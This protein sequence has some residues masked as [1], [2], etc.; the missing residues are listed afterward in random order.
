MT[1][2]QMLENQSDF[3]KHSEAWIVSSMPR[4]GLQM[5]QP[6]NVGDAW[7]KPYARQFHTEDAPTWRAIIEGRPLRGD[8][9]WPGGLE[10]S[11]YY[12]GFLRPGG[13]RYMA[14]AP[15]AAPVMEGYAGAIHVYRT[16]E[17]G[18]FSDQEL[19]RLSEIAGELNKA[20]S[21]A[22]AIR[23]PASCAV[24]QSWVHRP[25]TRQLVL[26]AKLKSCLG[27]MHDLDDRV[28]AQ[29]LSDA[30]KRLQHA[31]GNAVAARLAVPDTH[32]DLWTFRVMPYPY[33]PAFGQGPVLFYCMQPEFCDWKTIRSTD[34][35]ADESVAR[36]IPALQYMQEEFYKGPTLNQIAKTVHLSPFH[37]HRRFADLL[38]ITPKHFLL[39]CQIF[40]AK[41]FLAEGEKDLVEIAKM[42]GFAHQSHFTSRF[43][44]A[45]GLTPTR[46]RKFAWKLEQ[47]NGHG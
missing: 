31:N 41:K 27:D 9:C 39:E 46:W 26:D 32:G 14:V 21:D 1:F 10:A 24:P 25:R 3:V 37:F 17:L 34:V 29:I 43:K 4:G 16:A 12:R 22:R 8:E 45:T 11:T 7:L 38:G 28:A 23:T 36:L 33:Y 30:R 35:V 13:L 42:C 19:H 18:D 5:V 20:E 44:Q 15:L 6:A 40:Q 2:R 47:A